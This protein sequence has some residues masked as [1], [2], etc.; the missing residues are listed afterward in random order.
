MK[1]P[2]KTITETLVFLN[3]CLGKLAVYREL[4][5]QICAGSSECMAME[6]TTCQ[7]LRDLRLMLCGKT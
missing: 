6:Y 2:L 4:S 5:E 7:P 3:D 1:H